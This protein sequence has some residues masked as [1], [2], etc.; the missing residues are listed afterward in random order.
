MRERLR[1]GGD[2]GGGREVSAWGLN[3]KVTVVKMEEPQARGSFRK[4]SDSMPFFTSHNCNWI[5][6]TLELKTF[7]F[8]TEVP[9]SNLHDMNPNQS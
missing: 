4:P 5:W 8:S 7:G 6:K 1:V 2:G 9:T 3:P